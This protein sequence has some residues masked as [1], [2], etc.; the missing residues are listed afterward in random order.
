[1]EFRNELNHGSVKLLLISVD[2]LKCADPYC[3]NINGDYNPF[4]IPTDEMRF[5]IES[6]E[7]EV[8][9]DMIHR[10]GWFD[11]ISDDEQ[12]VLPRFKKQ[13]AVRLSF[14]VG[15]QAAV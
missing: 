2:C 15:R 5:L 12:D 6:E 9:N 13:F 11:R 3:K 1:M 14:W 7:R 8:P 4:P 10:S